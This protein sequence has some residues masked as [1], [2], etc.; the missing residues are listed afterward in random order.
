[1]GHDISGYAKDDDAQENEIAYL[2]RSAGSNMARD[3]YKALGAEKYDGGCSGIGEY[4]YFTEDQLRI[5]LT[6]IPEHSDY[7]PERQFIRDCIKHGGGG[8]WVAFC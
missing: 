7:E 6:K 5:A 4:A 2:R 3:I 1:M 8:A